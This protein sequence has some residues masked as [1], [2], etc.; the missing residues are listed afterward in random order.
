MHRGLVFK[1]LSASQNKRLK[2]DEENAY[3]IG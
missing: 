2:I 3:M 1:M